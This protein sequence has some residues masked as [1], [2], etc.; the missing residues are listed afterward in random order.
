MY[1]IIKLVLFQFS[2]ERA[3]HITTSTFNFLTSTPIISYLIKALFKLEDSR[4]EKQLWGLTFK[5]PVG[6]AAGFDKDGKYIKSMSTLGFGF[7]EVGTVT[8]R[9]QIGNPKPRL[10]RLKPDEAIINRMGFNN[11]GVDELVKNLK[12]LGD[13]RDFIL[14][15]NIGKNKDTPNDKAYED[16]LICFQ[17]L[18]DYVDYFVVNLSSP[19]TPGLRELQDKKPLSKILNT[20]LEE[21]SSK[22]I[23]KPILLKIAPDLNQAQL[24]DVIEIANELKIEGLIA[25]NTTIVRDGL[26]TDDAK[27]ESIG[28]GGL[29]G[30]PL[31]ARSTEVISYINTKSSGA[32][33]IIGVGGINSPQSAQKKIAAGA[34]L[35]QVYSGLIYEG[36]FLIK[37]IKKGLVAQKTE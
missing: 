35:I 23:K 31:Q 37:K 25:T 16:Y 26:I 13:Q 19:N 30:K 20:L 1:A 8:P 17:K 9:G 28:A 14:G 15:G 27:V 24:D 36:P 32:L 33:P 34:G 2:A 18:Y 6:L 29:S 3:H 5:N 21:R 4:L 22:K 12:S 7:I 10:F 11:D